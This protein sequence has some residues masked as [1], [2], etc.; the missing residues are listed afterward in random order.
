MMFVLFKG[1]TP[2]SSSGGGTAGIDINIA[3]CCGLS[4]V[5]ISILLTALKRIY[6]RSCVYY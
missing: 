6:M 2:V 3:V 4:T 5:D 1:N